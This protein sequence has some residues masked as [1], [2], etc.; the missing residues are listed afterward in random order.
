MGDKNHM[1]W[2][3]MNSLL[4]G[5]SFII[6]SL[7]TTH[8]WGAL[9]TYYSQLKFNWLLII[10]LLGIIV[11]MVEYKI[12][13]N[14][15]QVPKSL[16]LLTCGLL[17]IITFV[18]VQNIPLFFRWLP[19]VIIFVIY[20]LGASFSAA[21]EG[22]Q[23]DPATKTGIGKNYDQNLASYDR[24]K[25]IIVRID[26]LVIIS[27][28][29]ICQIG[30]GL[31]LLGG[32]IFFFQFILLGVGFYL[33]KW[34]V[35]QLENKAVNLNLFRRM[36]SWILIIVVVSSVAAGVLPVRFA[37]FWQLVGNN[38]NKLMEN[39][40]VELPTT[41]ELPSPSQE[42]GPMERTNAEGKQKSPEPSLVTK[43]FM[44]LLVLGNALVI[45]LAVIVVLRLIWEVFIREET[46]NIKELP[47]ILAEIWRQ[48][49]NLLKNW[50]ELFSQGVNQI[51]TSWQERKDKQN[52]TELTEKKEAADLS[53]VKVDASG[54]R[55][56]IIRL[57]LQVRNYF[58]EAGVSCRH[59]ETL[60]EYLAEAREKFAVYSQQISA[61]HYLIREAVYSN[62]QL[63]QGEVDKMREAVEQI[64]AD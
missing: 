15:R 18:L 13:A 48:I 44:G 60:A 45:I 4:Y 54:P 25:R 16:C 12:T 62:H 1:N 42:D 63:T 21:I 37:G 27:W 9:L 23:F 33:K 51:K 52:K 59:S 22:F 11:G 28:L 3:K 46:R 19:L 8:L 7:L 34:I 24:L 30:T 57:F 41:G 26:L 61:I 55:L 58:S 39:I 10:S 32:A 38:I 6:L 49:L 2:N 36:I 29:F 56:E 31:I 53:S 40:S 20:R 50:R 5:L 14:N 17:L 47:Q 64:T 43:I 35:W